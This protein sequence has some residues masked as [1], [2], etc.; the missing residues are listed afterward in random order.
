MRRILITGTSGLLG[1]N[2]A[3]EM[4]K[5]HIV[6]G[7]AKEQIYPPTFTAI[8]TDLLVPH[9]VERILDQVQPDWV[10]HCAALANLDACEADPEQARK[11]NSEIPLELASHVARGGARLLHISTDAVFDGQGG[12]YSENDFP[13]PLGIYAKTKLEGE[14]GVAEADPQ[15]V[16]ARINLFGWSLSGTRSLAE[17]FFYNLQG[18]KPVMGF[19]DVIFCP[20]LAN[21]LAQIFLKMFSLHL[22]GLFHVVSRECISK[23]Q[24][25]V[26][27]ARIFGLDE[28]LI[29][30]KSWEE[31]GLKAARAPNLNLRSEKLTKAIGEPLPDISSGLERF[32]RLYQEG[33]PQFLKGLG[34]YSIRQS[35]TDNS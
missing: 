13:N 5:E 4:A 23:Y 21:D 8:Q 35:V 26:E 14:H 6:F 3:L 31:A 2:L 10:I 34:N 17:Y 33:Y 19:T 30:P 7:L 20:L 16:I 29:T 12:N 27:I 22:N 25:G 18:G 9:T 24:F 32:Y 28:T 11:L 15:A 1:L